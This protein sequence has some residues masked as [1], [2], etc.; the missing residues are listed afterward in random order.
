MKRLTQA[1]QE[2]I[3][4]TVRRAEQWTS[5][6]IVPLIVDAADP[7][8]SADLLGGLAGMLLVL[9]V[10]LWL[11]IAWQP[12]PV[13][14]TL[15]AGLLAGWSLS[16]FTPPLKR[17]MVGPRLAAQEVYQR[18]VQA[19]FEHG[20]VNTRDRTGILIL[21]ALLERRVQVLAD[22]GIHAKVPEGTWDEVVRLVLDGIKRGSLADGLTA[23]VERCGQILARDFPRKPDDTN[24]LPDEPI[25]E[26]R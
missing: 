13:T 24:E 18:A 2:R 4:A 17:A 8:P 11:P 14:I 16:H 6:E 7:Y 22:A 15:L 20:L 23:A 26:R 25:L 5:G 3:T 19:F 9:I 21:V 10:W 12:L 1:E